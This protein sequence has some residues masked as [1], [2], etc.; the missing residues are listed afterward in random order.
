MGAGVCR[1]WALPPLPTCLTASQPRWCP[2]L[3]AQHGRLS[4]LLLQSVRAHTRSR[5]QDPYMCRAGERT[6]AQLLLAN[7]PDADRLAVAER[8]SS[9]GDA[10]S[11]SSAPAPLAAP[12]GVAWRTFSGNEI[13][14]LLGWWL[15]SN[16]K[17]RNPQVGCSY[18]G[19]KM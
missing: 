3:T 10:S 2:Q 19:A 7:D 1:R 15:W 6:G 5:N 9:G 11:S 18:G 4:A 17:R 14:I 12:G 16:F 8:A 13:G